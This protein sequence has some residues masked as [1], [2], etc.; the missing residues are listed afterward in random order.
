MEQL[1][2]YRCMRAHRP[3]QIDGAIDKGFWVDAIWSDDFVDIEGDKK[4]HPRH[5]TRIKML[6]DD[7]GLY[8]AAALQE[9]HLWATLTERDS[10]IFHDN[11]FEVFLDPNG[12]GVMYAELE[13]NALN[14]VWDLLLVKPYR[15]GGPALHGWQIKGLET[16]VRLRGTL[17]DPSDLDDGWDVEIFMP[18]SGLKE[19]CVCDCPPKAHDQWRIN[20][21]RVQWDLEVVDG[22]YQKIEGR[23]EH[24]WVWSSQGVIDM[25][26]PEHWG[27]LEFFE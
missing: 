8:I 26:Q 7:D 19:I 16:A 18:W 20:F 1:A 9:P 23:P 5:R 2:R 12:A 27:I 4:P 14:T 15:D 24:N 17:N 3:R 25:H 21:S 22:A 6:W 10:I 13:I 11:D